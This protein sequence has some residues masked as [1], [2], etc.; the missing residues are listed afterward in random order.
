MKKL[1]KQELNNSHKLKSKP[2]ESN[3]NVKEDGSIK[4][5]WIQKVLKDVCQSSNNKYELSKL[6]KL[7]TRPV[8][9][10]V[11]SIGVILLAFL[12]AMLICMPFM[13]IGAMIPGLLGDPI[14]TFLTKLNVHPWL[15]SIF[16]LILPNTLYFSLAMSA[17]VLGV[18][19]VFGYLEEIGFLA[20]AAYQF[21]GVLSKLGLQGKAVAPVLMGF[22]CTIGGACGTRVMDN[23]GQKMLAMAVVWAV[24]CGAIWGIMPVISGMFFPA[25]GTLLVCLGIII[26][27]FVLMWV[28]SKNIW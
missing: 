11:L 3:N 16:S 1:F 20:R 18:N 4:Y 13:S 27:M 25:W 7:L 26:Y 19:L 21:D 23:W 12:V 10:K 2:S 15:V 8:L 6:D 28:V 17:F 14:N 5:E 9:G 22:G 24:P